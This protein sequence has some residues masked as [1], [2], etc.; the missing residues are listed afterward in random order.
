MGGRVGIRDG[1]PSQR[2]GPLKKVKKVRKNIKKCAEGA[3]SPIEMIRS[4]KKWPQYENINNYQFRFNSRTRLTSFLSAHHESIGGI[5]FG[6]AMI[7]FIPTLNSTSQLILA[8]LIYLSNKSHLRPNLGPVSTLYPNSSWDTVP[9]H[10]GTRPNLS[11][12]T[13]LGT[14]SQLSVPTHL[15]MRPRWEIIE[16]IKKNPKSLHSRRKF[17]ESTRDEQRELMMDEFLS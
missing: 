6:H 14:P 9:T 1:G 3:P 8:Q 11:V 7:F 4:C 15:G 17:H 10:L 12:P 13:H 5:A 2:G 16:A